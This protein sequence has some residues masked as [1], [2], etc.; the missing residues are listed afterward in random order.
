MAKT[1]AERE[2]SKYIRE[3]KK[4]IVRLEREN[5]QLRKSKNRLEH[6]ISE[7]EE[8]EDENPVVDCKPA[9]NTS[10]NSCPKCGSYDIIEFPL[11]SGTYYKCHCSKGKLI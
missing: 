2:E 10:R 8:E 7:M 1:R 5:A 6:T 4:R 11:N 9:K 3:L